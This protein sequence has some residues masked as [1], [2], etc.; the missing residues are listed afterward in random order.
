MRPGTMSLEVVQGDT[1]R[2]SMRLN[3]NVGTPDA[4]VLEPIDLR[5]HVGAAQMRR[6][7]GHTELQ[8]AFTV[9]CPPVG[10]A[11]AERGDVVI[12]L[13]AAQASLVT[14]S[15]VWDLQTTSP[16]GEVRT[17]VRGP[18]ELIPEAT[19]LDE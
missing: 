13:T 3:R 9:T 10:G 7:Y 1:F 19:V 8:A 18:V 12:A 4:P 15:G 17:W 14:K 5:G 2:Q 16:D 6:K 11:E